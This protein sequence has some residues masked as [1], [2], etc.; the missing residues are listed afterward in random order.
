MEPNC[1]IAQDRVAEP[2][3]RHGDRLVALS[4]HLFLSYPIQADSLR[5][6]SNKQNHS[7]STKDT[8]D[9]KGHEGKPFLPF[10]VLL[11]VLVYCCQPFF[12]MFMYGTL[13]NPGN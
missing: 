13:P 7:R 5:N 12:K 11:H 9:T 8:K 3:D 2:E 4:F 10:F 6:I 1:I